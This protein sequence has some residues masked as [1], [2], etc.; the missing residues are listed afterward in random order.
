MIQFMMYLDDYYL[1]AKYLF[2]EID[3]D[4]EWY[5]KVMMDIFTLGTIILIVFAIFGLFFVIFFYVL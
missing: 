2:I 1:G 3:E 5:S 4:K